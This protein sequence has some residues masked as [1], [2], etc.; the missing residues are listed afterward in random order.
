MNIL[1]NPMRWRL[2]LEHCEP[3]GKTSDGVFHQP[4]RVD[5]KQVLAQ[6]RADL[7]GKDSHR[8]VTLSYAWL[9]NQFGHFALGFIPTIVLMISF[10]GR[11][12]GIRAALLV[13]GLWTV[14][15]LLNFLGPLL[16]ETRKTC[17]PPA[18]KN[19]A[20]DTLTDIF[21]FALGSFCAVAFVERGGIPVWITALIAM[22]LIPM[23]RYWYGTKIYQQQAGFPRQ[24]RLAQWSGFLDTED[25]LAAASWAAHASEGRHLFVVGFDN[26]QCS[27]LG[28]AI[29]TESAIRHRSCGYYTAPAFLAELRKPFSG[30][31]GNCSWHRRSVLVVDEIGGNALGSGSFARALAESTGGTQCRSA[32]RNRN[33]IWILGEDVDGAQR[34]AW[35]K[36]LRELGIDEEMIECVTVLRS[37]EDMVVVRKGNE[38]GQALNAE[39]LV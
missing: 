29:G 4:A 23:S 18:W 5:G 35:A 27:D 6:L 10:N 34:A 1:Q 11:H 17:F 12:H 24:I 19:I 31:D 20:F 25:R 22:A 3:L 33:V 36:M 26:A 7:I 32:L 15:E 39:A 30:G 38:V 2:M 16:M 28:V 8:G 14:F 13:A 9:A 37:G 21:F